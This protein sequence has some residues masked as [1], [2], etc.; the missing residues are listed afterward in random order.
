LTSAGTAPDAAPAR[1][2]K[3]ALF[4]V[5]NLGSGAGD[6]AVVRCSAGP[7]PAPTWCSAATSVALHRRWPA[8]PRRLWV[9]QAGTAQ[10]SRVRVD[11]PNSVNLLR[12][13]AAGDVGVRQGRQLTVERWDC[14]AEAQRF[15]RV[16]VHRLHDGIAGHVTAEPDGD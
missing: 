9:V 6:A 11:A 8:L 7:R 15:E 5:F 16:A 13:A 10:S 3:P 2:A 4:V 12:I 1:P 14:G